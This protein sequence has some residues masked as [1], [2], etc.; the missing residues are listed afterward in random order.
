MYLRSSSMSF[1]SGKEE[2]QTIKIGKEVYTPL[3]QCLRV[4]LPW[5]EF[6]QV[7]KDGFSKLDA[8]LGSRCI[9]Q[10]VHKRLFSYLGSQ[11][12]QIVCLMGT[13]AVVCM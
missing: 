11:V 2:P 10:L 1:H 4:S 7:D 9:D 13:P 5:V 8:H 6:L 12:D 3:F